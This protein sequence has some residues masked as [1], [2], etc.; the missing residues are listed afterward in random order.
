M[1]VGITWRLAALGFAVAMTGALIV[2]VTL[3]LQWRAVEARSKLTEITSES[4]RIADFFESQLRH[5]NDKMRR[6]ASF[7]EPASWL[8]F[9]QASRDLKIWIDSYEVRASTEPE[10]LA[11]QQMR[12]AFADYMKQAEKLHQVIQSER[13]EKSGASLAECNDFFE[14]ARRLHDLGKTLARAHYDTQND[15]LSQVHKTLTHLRLS[16]LAFVALLFIFGAALAVVVSRDLIAPLKVKLVESQALAERHEKLASL[17][18]LA[19]GVAHEIRN[20]LTA[21]KTA[22]FM[23]QRKASPGS[24]EHEDAELIEREIVRLERIVNEF[25]DFARPSEPRPVVLS[26]DEP[27]RELETLLGPQLAESRIQLLR[28]EGKPMRIKADPSQ[29]KQVLINL[30]QNAADSIGSDGFI[31]LRTREGRRPLGSGEA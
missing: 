12:A 30:V 22:L 17:G 29:L 21:I 31:K 15:F 14:Q 7:Q 24:P 10:K 20:P 25:L 28:E 6:Y 5:A 1:K 19:A 26:A 23:Q 8:E 2:A 16:V 4:F 18:M 13:A 27:L 11:V 9:Q 3:S